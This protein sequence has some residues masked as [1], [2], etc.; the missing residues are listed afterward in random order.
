MQV[1]DLKGEMLDL[2]YITADIHTCPNLMQNK[3]LSMCL[4]G[5]MEVCCQPTYPQA[6]RQGEVFASVCAWFAF[7]RQGKYEEGK[8]AYTGALSEYDDGHKRYIGT[9]P[10]FMQ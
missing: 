9:Q 4:S 3:L 5:L 1:V 6:S 8:A 7:C 10:H 2:N